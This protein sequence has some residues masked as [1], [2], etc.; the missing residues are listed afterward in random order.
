MSSNLDE[1]IRKYRN[2]LIT[3]SVG[4]G[5]SPKKAEE[6]MFKAKENKEGNLY[7]I[8]VAEPGG[9]D[10][11]DIDDKAITI[12]MMKEFIETSNHSKKK[13]KEMLKSIDEK[14]LKDSKTGISSGL[15]TAV[16]LA[17]ID[18]NQKFCYIILDGNNIK[19]LNSKL[20]YDEVDQRIAAS[21]NGL[22]KAEEMVL[23][24]LRTYDRRKK[25]KKT[26]KD[27]RKKG[28]RRTNENQHDMIYKKNVITGR[29]HE[30][31]DE[32]VIMVPMEYE[33]KNAVYIAEKILQ[34]I[35]ESQI[36]RLSEMVV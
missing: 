18:K 19:D 23:G 25:A 10:K 29:K 31:G 30:T 35:Y 33:C 8:V 7:N 28:E 24:V 1:K 22:N 14:L 16:Q 34:R 9:K 2:D 13:K 21:G 3:F 20:G 36:K 12:Q 26:G 6:A 5:D 11:P 32:F 17:E 4:I 27:K 15:G